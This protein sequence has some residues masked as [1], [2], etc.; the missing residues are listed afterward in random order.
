[1]SSITLAVA[2]LIAFVLLVV[3]TCS[4]PTNHD[5]FVFSINL[6]GVDAEEEWPTVFRGGVLGVCSIF[7]GPTEF[8]PEETWNCAQVVGYVVRISRSGV[9]IG[10]SSPPAD[11]P[12]FPQMDDDRAVDVPLSR[13][14]VLSPIAAA[15]AGLA[16]LISAVTAVLRDKR[17]LWSIAA[18]GVTALA[19]LLSWIAFGINL[20]VALNVK[21]AVDGT[22]FGPAESVDVG[23]AAFLPLGS[24]IAMTA[25]LLVW[26]WQTRRAHTKRGHVSPGRDEVADSSSTLAASPEPAPKQERP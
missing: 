3:T 5:I 14:M 6:R 12:G 26:A 20:G 24:A 1:M 25:G 11:I 17:H 4:S 18:G 21:R 23:A 9:G 22:E 10:T 19:A 15:F 16:M 8:W 7:S 13:A 2:C